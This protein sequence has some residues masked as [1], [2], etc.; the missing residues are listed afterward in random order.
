M[1]QP[2]VKVNT[3]SID[4]TFK[5]NF[6]NVKGDVKEIDMTIRVSKQFDLETAIERA[7]NHIR[8]KLINF[9]SI[10]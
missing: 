1:T 5:V 9:H 8:E 10:A 4:L 6:V 2:K 3:K 7:K